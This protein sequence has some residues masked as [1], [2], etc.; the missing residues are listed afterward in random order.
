MPR[1]RPI[2]TA[3]GLKA[4]QSRVT[5][6]SNVASALPKETTVELWTPRLRVDDGQ[7]MSYASLVVRIFVIW[8][9]NA[10]NSSREYA[11]SIPFDRANGP[12]QV[13]R[14][15]TLMSR[16]GRSFNDINVAIYTIL[17][18]LITFSAIRDSDW[19]GYVFDFGSSLYLALDVG[20]ASAMVTL[21]RWWTYSTLAVTTV[22]TGRWTE[23]PASL[24]L[25]V[26]FPRQ[27]VVKRVC[28]L[29]DFSRGCSA[30]ENAWLITHQMAY[31][32]R[33]EASVE[34]TRLVMPVALGKRLL[35][36]AEHVYMPVQYKCEDGSIAHTFFS[37]ALSIHGVKG[38]WCSVSTLTS[39]LTVVKIPTSANDFLSKVGDY[40]LTHTAA[41]LLPLAS[42]IVHH[43]RTDK[44]MSVGTPSLSGQL[45]L[46]L[47]SAV[48]NDVNL[49]DAE[50]VFGGTDTFIN[51]LVPYVILQLITMNDFTSIKLTGKTLFFVPLGLDSTSLDDVLLVAS[52]NLMRH[53][54]SKEIFN[55]VFVRLRTFSVTEIHEP[56]IG[57]CSFGKDL[58]LRANAIRFRTPTLP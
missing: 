20:P 7:F 22:V 56:F 44:H 4:L 36:S 52:R 29:G 6:D 15:N 24:Q 48:T 11:S 12:D 37:Q 14:R 5:A 46:P 10:P 8:F 18:A 16:Y 3:E 33:G 50:M 34:V 25:P 23:L 53:S 35:A 38:A 31:M 54:R 47:L 30:S 49:G 40:R 28:V 2:K 17:Q 21:Q 58:E 27:S 41:A 51:L 57:F 45:P 9:F 55:S 32:Q 39:L 26:L 43:S 42:T 1:P 13:R 19:K